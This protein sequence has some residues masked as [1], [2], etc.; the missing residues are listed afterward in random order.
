MEPSKFLESRQIGAADQYHKR[1]E[2]RLPTSNQ[3]VW[4]SEFPQDETTP[5]LGVD[6][7]RTPVKGCSKGIPKGY[8]HVCSSGSFGGWSKG[9][10]RKSLCC[11]GGGMLHLD[12]T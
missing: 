5:S 12:T 3:P 9:N 10:R 1:E 6:D 11:A 2:G 4:G 8:H 7:F